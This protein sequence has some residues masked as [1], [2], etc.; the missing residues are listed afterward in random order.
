MS[1]PML[2]PNVHSSAVMYIYLI[3][4]ELLQYYCNRSKLAIIV[5]LLG[6]FLASVEYR[7]F[8]KGINIGR[9][10][11]VIKNIKRKKMSSWLQ[12]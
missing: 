3:N 12:Q 8:V 10:H 4:S 11:L 9:L 6:F 2:S 5:L 1:D 7:S